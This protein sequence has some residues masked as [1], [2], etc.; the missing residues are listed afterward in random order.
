[1]RDLISLSPEEIRETLVRGEI[2]VAVVGL[3]R[4]GLPTAVSFAEGGANVIGIDIDPKVVSEVSRGKS[5][6][7]D[8]PGL[9]ELLSRMV[10]SGRLSVTTGIENVEK[11]DMVIVAVPTPVNEEKVPD[12]SYINSACTSISKHLKKGSL[13]VIESTVGPGYVERVIVPLL[14]KGSGMKAGCD[15]GVASC[16]ERANP[17][18]ILRD[19]KSVPRIVGGIDFKSLEAAATIYEKVFGVKVVRV[20]SPKAA[21]AAKLMENIFRDVNIAL[22]NEFALLFERLGIDTDEVIRACSTKYNFVPHFPGAGVGGPCLPSNSYYLITESIRVGNIPY[23]V[24][25]AREINDRMPEHVVTLVTEAMNDVGKV[26][27]GSRITVLGLSYKPNIKDL[28]LSPMEKVCSRLRKM[29]ARL[30]L[31]DPYYR[32][33]TVYGVKVAEDVENAVSNAD[34]ILVG[35]AHKEIR[36]LDIGMLARLSNMPAAMVDTSQAVNPE[37]ARKAGL[38]YR[39]VGRV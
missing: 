32:G 24:R 17:G 38:V 20:S 7:I 5:K 33:E 1:M 12:Y 6:F 34:C 36:N 27:K 18:A 39:G 11:A 29:G 16:P 37:E 2:T 8:E 28:Q 19:M 23:L 4:I 25:M 31:Y 9:N 22:A 35:T 14:E 15:F 13:V 3:G 26:V 21:N 30:A 10:G